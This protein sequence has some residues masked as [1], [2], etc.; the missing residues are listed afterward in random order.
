MNH[1]EL[2]A[3]GYVKDGKVYLKS[4]LGQP[5]RIIGDVKLGE[6]ESIDYFIRRFEL[7]R[8]KVNSMVEAM[9]AAENKGSYLMQVLHLKEAIKSFNA[10]GPFEELLEKLEQAEGRINGLIENN[11]VKNYDIKTQLLERAKEALLI[12]DPREVIREMKEVRFAWMT[13]GS[14]AKEKETELE[15]AFTKILDDFQVIKDKYTAERTI[16]IEIRKQKLQILLDTAARLNT[17]QPEVEQ[18]FFKFKKLEEEWKGVGNIPK[19]YYGPLFEQFKRIKKTIAKYA[20]KNTGGN[21]NQ[22]P[23]PIFIPRN[24]PPH[25]EP[26]YENL[27]RRVQLIEDAKGLLRMDL[28]QANELAKEIQAQWKM[29]GQIPDQFKSEVFNQFNAISDR[30]FESSYLARVVHTKFP[31]F[32][33]MSPAEQLQ[34]KIE[35]MDEIIIKE[36]MNVKVTQ[37]E[38]EFMSQE[39]R[40]TDENRSRFSR[41]NTSVRKLRMKNKILFELRRELD[42]IQNPGYGDQNRS[43]YSSRPQGSYNRDQGS[44][45]NRNREGN[46]QRDNG[47]GSRPQGS[48]YQRESSSY[49]NR[50]SGSG[51]GRDNGYGNR[52]GGYNRE[53]TY[54]NRDYNSNRD[55]GYGNR[56]QSY[57]RDNG[58]GNREGAN[59]DNGYGNRDQS[60]NRD[61]GY[62]NRDQSFN[63]DNGYGNRDNTYQRS[64]NYQN[65]DGGNRYGSSGE[66]RQYG[67]RGPDS[68]YQNR[69]SGQYAQEQSRTYGNR[70]Q[71]SDSA[72]EKENS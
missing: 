37:A 34:A 45:Y 46:Y 7:I 42:Q 43:S 69:Q 60:Y 33:M 44:G 35:A 63:R 32:R 50:P 9:E 11:R 71:E 41:L 70:S 49:G 5:D 15:D 28:R 55:N 61:N 31:D 8:H 36:D 52:E 51:Y 23:R 16:E 3:M 72:G 13:V 68:G 38:F 54:G 56:D 53:S 4:I 30:I 12:E 40:A 20:R 21:R 27:R 10:I 17:Y 59:R 19:V 26:L 48:G 29:A 67:D 39:E 25:E 66:R 14:A 6:Q 2:R 24:Y 57:N 1:A 62:G 65:R 58:Y 18:S 64:P 47:Y 22:G